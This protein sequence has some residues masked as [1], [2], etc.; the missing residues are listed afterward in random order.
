MVLAKITVIGQFY[1]LSAKYGVCQ[2]IPALYQPI[3]A[4]VSQ[5]NPFVSQFYGLS[6]NPQ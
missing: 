6:A 3:M 2:P 1:T 5:F 4:F